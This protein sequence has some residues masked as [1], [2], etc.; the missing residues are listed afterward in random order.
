MISALKRD[1]KIITFI[2]YHGKKKTLKRISGK[3][4]LSPKEVENKIKY[5][6]SRFEIAIC[7]Y[8]LNIQK[9]IHNQIIFQ[10]HTNYKG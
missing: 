6:P 8:I 5:K 2:K 1:L 4:G 9:E 7:K 10:N 3:L